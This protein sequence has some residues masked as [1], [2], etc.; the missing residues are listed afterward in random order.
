MYAPSFELDYLA[1][2]IARTPLGDRFSKPINGYWRT[3]S[4]GGRCSSVQ[5]F[6]GSLL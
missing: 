1:E 6:I 5:A 3:S 2:I 4:K